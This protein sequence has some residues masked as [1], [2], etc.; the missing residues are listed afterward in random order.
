MTKLSSN[1]TY[2][3]DGPECPVCGF[4]ITPD[5]GYY[6]DPYKFDSFTCDECNTEIAV[7]VQPSCSWRCTI[8]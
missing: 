1:T 5:E 3:D 4:T 2:S 8:K 7:E 6:F